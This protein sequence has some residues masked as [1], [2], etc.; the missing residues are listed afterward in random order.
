MK[1]KLIEAHF[2][3]NGSNLIMRKMKLTTLFS[4]L[5]FLTSWGTSLSQTT[6]LSLHLKNVPVQEMISQI[7]DQSEFYFLYQD[8]VFRKDQKITIQV[9]DASVESILQ[10]AADQASIQYRIIDRQIVLMPMGETELPAAL[11]G[12]INNQQTQKKDVSGTVTDT[13]GASL[14]GVS[15]VIKGTT[16]GTITD[17]NGKFHLL[18]P[19]SAKKLAFS[20]VG[21]K[22]QE[23]EIGNQNLINVTLEDEAVGVD[24][25]VVVGYGTQKKIN[26]TGAVQNIT[27]KDLIK[28]SASNTSVA[29][30][31]LIPGV[32]V[33]TSSGRPGYDGAGITVRGSGSLNS[34]TAPLV[35]I[36]G[37][38]G[39]MNFLDMNTI[40]SISVLKDAASASIYGSRASNGVILVTT[41][42]SK[43]QPL[44]ISYNGYVG[45]NT[46]TALPDPVNAIEY[47]EAINQANVNAGANK[48]YTD[49]LITQ[50]KTLGADNQNRYETNWRKEIIKD[51]A[52]THN[53][54][55]SLSGGSKDI[56]IFAN[57]A[58]YFQDGNIKNNSYD[59]MTLRLNTDARVTNWMKAGVD[60]NI[61]QSKNI[62][63]A[64]DTP[65]SII[66]KAT[67]FVPI[68]SGRNSDGTWG[69]GQNGDNPIASAEASGISTSITPELALR[70]FV[71]INPFK[72][73][74]MTASYS[75]N[76]LETKGDYFITPFDTY[77]YGVYKT[78]YP[79]AG[80][81][82]Y[83]GWSQT[84]SN[85]FNLQT[86][87]EKQLANHYLKVL[88][89]MQTSEKK[90]RSFSATRTGFDFAGYEDL[91]SGN[92]ATA[93]NAGTH[94]DWTM[95]SFYSRINYNFKDRYLL[96]LNGRWDASSRF[97]ADQR[98]GFF[99][100]ASVGWRISEE[101]FY[102]PIKH[103]V[104]NLKVRGSY[105]TLGNQDISIN[106]YEQYYPYAATI[107]SG[108]GY[109]FD[110]I[111]GSGATQSQ[112]ANE[113][114]TWEKSSQMNVGVDADLL[115]SKLS[116]SFDYYIRDINDMLQQFPIPLYVGLSSSWENAGSMRNNGWDV[117]LNWRD[118]IG[119]VDY[120]ITGNLA[121]VKNKVTNLYGKEYVGTQITREG[122]QLGSW[123]G[124]LSDGYFQNQTEIDASP[125]YGT[126]ANVKPGFIKYKDISGKNGTPD[127]VI[128]DYDR[129]VLGNPS[130]RY[131]FSLNLGAEWKNFD[132]TLFLQGV[133]KKEIYYAS[134]GARPFYIGR[135]MMR[136]QLDT[137]TPQNTDAKFPLLLIDG[138]GSNP[139][140][141]IS[142]FWV[143]SGAY[144]RVKNVVIGYTL[145][146]SLLQKLKIDNVRFYASG[147]NLFTLTNAYKGYD[148]EESVSS[149]S[150]Y[151]LMQTY[152]FG[153]DIR[154]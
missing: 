72:G 49:D 128:D 18:V 102:Q 94:W 57:A 140:N 154:F 68:F 3:R 30:Q 78:T 99:P 129:T 119:N 60:V 67:T 22:A 115:N 149:G 138:S 136:N 10:Q 111:L 150:F 127:G 141:I 34:S 31:G 103:I 114:I 105:G 124:Y 80:T 37:V 19:S 100:S 143:K 97:T 4:F 24:E 23:I 58:Y 89:G 116:A 14:P 144:M 29:L 48:T 11:R 147:Q 109:W 42:R 117:T 73:F 81:S 110:K 131:T 126:K 87:Y 40:E 74:D 36:D 44:K 20:F 118:K 125:V 69:Y 122:G 101:E 50:Y 112:V 121:D 106:G 153:V 26:L 5:L 38:E 1:K 55:V 25:V 135:S 137:W 88:G 79:P 33:T 7:E 65:E 59:R 77:E 61:R 53:H 95:L 120:H 16:Q 64:Y 151:P 148:P 76:R 70:G 32:T 41:K 86:S 90:G 21:M 84:T 52:L 28:R 9:N 45:Y 13:K 46:P 139:N 113:K 85:E 71:T 83:D 107:G 130:P 93:S 123:Y 15:I 51:M 104:S 8:D 62:S 134:Y 12:Q 92:I 132:F 27:S 17:I 152:T 2:F 108:Y 39:Y 6:K 82:K 91:N 54:S 56:S 35:L 63:P 66:C 142:D 96:E 75:S 133:G 146:K 47:M 145:P 98:W 43:E